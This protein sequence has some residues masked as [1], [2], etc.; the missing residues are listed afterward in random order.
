VGRDKV[1]ISEKQV[2]ID[3]AAEMPDWQ[4]REFNRA[5]IFF[6]EKKYFLRQKSPAQKPYRLR[7]VLEPWPVEA[8]TGGGSFT[9]DADA[10]AERDAAI[11][12][13]HFE[14]VARAFLYLFYPFLGL[15]WSGTKDKL[16]RFGIVPR[17]VTGIS[18]M[19]TFGLIML[20]G[21]FAKMLLMGSMKTGVVAVG[22][23]IRAFYGRDLLELGPIS[24]PVVWL[25]VVFFIFLVLDLLIRYSQHLREVDSPW[26]F[27]EWLKCLVPRKRVVPVTQPVTETSVAAVAP[28]PTLPPAVPDAPV[29]APTPLIPGPRFNTD[30]SPRA[31]AVPDAP[32]AVTPLI[33]GPRFEMD[34]APATD[35]GSKAA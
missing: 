21:V 6:Q 8:P 10:V 23:M 11:K 15:L 5:I 22:G 16:A 34:S 4:V 7:Y 26:G 14:D 18:I 31:E 30:S 13:G 35:P 12:Q 32:V 29:A 27:L 1:T 9:Y 17:T 19:L 2:I 24:I 28:A 3:A 20:S 33:P 25:D